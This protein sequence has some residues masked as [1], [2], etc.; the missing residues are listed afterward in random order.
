MVQEQLVARGIRDE[1]VLAAMAQIPRHLF[2]E[3]ALRDRAYDD[4]PLPIGER[5]T[6]SQPY[7]VALMT[8]ALALSGT[9]KVL[10]IG[11]GCGY[12]AAVLAGLAARVCSIERIPTLFNQAWRTL[13]ALHYRNV[14]IRQG[15]GSYGMREEAP[16]D[17]I[18][19]TACAPEI[20][21][22]LIEQLK[23]GGRMI[24][25]VGNP[26]GQVLKKVLKNPEGLAIT[27]LSPCLFV[28]LIG[29]GGFSEQV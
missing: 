18:I 6:I 19:V 10:E 25:P 15:D 29:A 24:L 28:P 17:A 14:V 12:Q 21:P 23:V 5:Q 8:E 2:V 9:E 7:I 27:P 4:H 13:S 16:F 22:I 1:R 11:A 3:E 26:E 20:P